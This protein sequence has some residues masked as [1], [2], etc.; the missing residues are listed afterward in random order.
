MVSV[1]LDTSFLISLYTFRPTS[2][3]A[4]S[5]IAGLDGTL[6]INKLQVFEFENAIRHTAWLYGKDRSLGFF[7]IQQAET[8]I[9]RLDADI[10]SGVLELIPCDFGAVIEIAR[11]ISNAR[12]WRGGFRGVDLLHVAAA[13]H[14][15]VKRFLSF[16]GAQCKLAE[17]EG[18]E[19][20]V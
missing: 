15:R 5:A 1:Y 8:A 4:I 20:G 18:F 13:R 7:S 16:D 9:A 12:T 14:L 3:A 2:E 6:P 17:A 10:E 19:V 11:K